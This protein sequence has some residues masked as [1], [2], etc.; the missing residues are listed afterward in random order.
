MNSI[1][2]NYIILLS[3]TFKKKTDNAKNKRFHETK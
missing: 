1:N 2:Y 3:H